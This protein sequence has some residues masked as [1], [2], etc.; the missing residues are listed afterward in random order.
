ML[1]VCGVP[2]KKRG[3]IAALGAALILVSL[4]PVA[5]AQ[6]F[7]PGERARA[8]RMACA[9]D[10]Q[11]FCRDVLPGGGRILRCLSRHADLVSQPCFQ[12]LTVWGLT[13]ANAYRMCLPE[14]RKAVRD[15]ASALRACTGL[16]RA[17]RRQA[18]QGLSQFAHRSGAS[19]RPGG[20][21]AGT[22][23]VRPAGGR[24]LSLM[25]RVTNRYLADNRRQCRTSRLAP[26]G[27]ISAKGRG[28]VPTAGAWS[29]GGDSG[30]GLGAAASAQLDE[31]RQAC[32]ADAARLCPGVIGGGEAIRATVGITAIVGIMRMPWGV[33]AMRDGALGCQMRYAR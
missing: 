22:V 7:L 19:Q 23:I 12:A 21:S 25:C 30:R 16:S 2:L 13:A 3:L 4:P 10:F 31:V 20:A 24:D 11:R 6:D 5:A 27:F 9:A 14:R 8:V 1:A 15:V 28:H 17:E 33:A 29:G 26:I 18:E 32:R